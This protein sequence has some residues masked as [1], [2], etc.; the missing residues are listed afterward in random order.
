MTITSSHLDTMK[1]MLAL[2]QD[3]HLDATT[4]QADYQDDQAAFALV[5][6]NVALQQLMAR[7]N[8]HYQ[9][10]V[11]TVML[12]APHLTSTLFSTFSHLIQ[13]LPTYHVDTT[14]YQQRLRADSALAVSSG[15]LSFTRFQ[16][17]IQ[18]TNSDVNETQSVLLRAETATTLQQFHHDVAAYSAAH[19]YNDGY[20]G[21]SYALDTSYLPDNFGNDADNLLSQ[22]MSVSDLQS[23]LQTAQVLQY[24]HQLFELDNSD[25]TPY[26]Q[27]HQADTLALQ[28][29]HLTH[30]Q[31]IVVSLAKQTLRLYQDGK[32]VRAFLVTT[33][34]AE[35]P[36]PPGIYSVVN[37]LAP[38]EFRSDE[39][40][41][42][43]YWYPPTHINYAILMRGDGYFIHDSWWRDDY[44]PGTQFPHADSGGDAYAMNGSHGCVNLP[45]DEAAWLYNNTDWNTAIV[46]Y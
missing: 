4:L 43:P 11:V 8:A 30:G 33:G 6:S 28:H 14:L 25:N 1:S 23:A 36:S 20:D 5:D 26:D 24:N 3:N 46:V 32:L 37:R 19:M 27:V 18:Q 17:F 45:T 9:Q 35:R 10:G 34:R 12:A 16:R 13:Q 21:H 7:M 15:P 22:A 31:A 44:G 42:S 41:G 38:T 29:Y 39:P 40:P 2:L